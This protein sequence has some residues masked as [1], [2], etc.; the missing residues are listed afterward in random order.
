VKAI[1][2]DVCIELHVNILITS[3]TG[4]YWRELWTDFGLEHH[5][6]RD[7][8]LAPGTPDSKVWDFCQRKHMALITANRN[9]D[10]P[11]SLETA[12]RTRNT[13]ESLP[14]FT[15]GNAE[16]ILHS[17][18]YVERVV[19]RLLDMLMH[20]DRVRGTGRIWLP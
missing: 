7:L 3:L 9:E 15:I 18:E 17:R 6:F 14:V 19:E 11:D 4:T 10:G 16:E 5:T 12:I 13:G 20:I 8:G 2:S 1:L